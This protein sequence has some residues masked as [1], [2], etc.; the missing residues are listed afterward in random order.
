MYVEGEQARR[1][2]AEYE[3]AHGL[4]EATQR[5]HKYTAQLSAAFVTV[6]VAI[7]LSYFFVLDTPALAVR[8]CSSPAAKPQLAGCLSG[9]GCCCLAKCRQ[10][11]LLS[12]WLPLEPLLPRKQ[13]ISQALTLK[14]HGVPC[15]AHAAGSCLCLEQP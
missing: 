1:R 12:C 3:S 6:V 10:H 7:M 8:G 2:S 9:C 11:C 14:R 4:C 13:A 15:T 5:M